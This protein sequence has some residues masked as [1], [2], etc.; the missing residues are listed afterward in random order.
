MLETLELIGRD[1]QSRTKYLLHR[2]PRIRRL[3][4]AG[5]DYAVIIPAMFLL[6][7]LFIVIAILIKL[8]SP[9][10]VFHRRRVKGRGGR[11]FKLLS[12]RTLYIDSEARLLQNREDWVALLRGQCLDYDPRMTRTGHYLRRL[13][14]DHLP[15]I[16]N[17]LARDM[18]L[19]GPYLLTK[20]DALYI[21]RK[22][23][24][25]IRSELPGFTGLWQVSAHKISRK[26]R[27]QLEVE[28]VHNWSPALDLRILFATFASL[29]QEEAA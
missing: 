22:R 12:F 29:R 7:P 21:N 4:K 17:I 1:N 2:S 23:L 25:I 24:E 27:A 18:S 19:V 16:F 8:E 9:G 6:A 28:Y 5:F 3:T 20:K 10:P 26:E 11:E 15:R 14:L 13:G